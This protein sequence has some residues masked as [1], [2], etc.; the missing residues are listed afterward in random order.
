MLC[1]CD[2]EFYK[3]LKEAHTKT[4]KEIGFIFFDLNKSKCFSKQG[5]SYHWEDN[6]NYI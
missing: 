3:C 4:S 2:K 6:P 1:K 5:E